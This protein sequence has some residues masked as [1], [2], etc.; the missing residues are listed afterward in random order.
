M[1]GTTETNIRKTDR[2]LVLSVI[3]GEK[4]KNSTGLT[5][6]SLFT[7][8][9]QLHAVMN[10]QTCFWTFKYERGDTPQPLKGT[11]TSFK[12]LLKFA[13]DYY[14]KRNIEIK[15]VKD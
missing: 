7:G 10:P 5:D 9:N 3:D 1:Y 2:V 14:K 13:E 12:A 11:F 4:A 15:E 6:T 8:S